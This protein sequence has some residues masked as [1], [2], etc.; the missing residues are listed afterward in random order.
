MGEPESPPPEPLRVSPGVWVSAALLAGGGALAAFSLPRLA[1]IAP[2][3]EAFEI[4]GLPLPAIV[5]LTIE[6]QLVG[7]FVLL[8]VLAPIAVLGSTIAR[9]PL[10]TRVVTGLAGA[11]VLLAVG[12]S[13]LGQLSFY[14]LVEG[15]REELAR[16][17][18]EPGRATEVALAVVEELRQAVARGV[19]VATLPNGETRRY[20]ILG[21]PGLPAP[22]ASLP[23]Y[24]EAR[25]LPGLVVLPWGAEGNTQSQREPMLLWPAGVAGGLSLEALQ[26]KGGPTWTLEIGGPS[27]GETQEGVPAVRFPAVTPAQH[28]GY[29]YALRLK[30]ARLDRASGPSYDNGLGSGL[31]PPLSR[32]IGAQDPFCDEL[33]EVQ[34]QVFR[35]FDPAHEGSLVPR[36]NTPIQRH[37]TLVALPG[38]TP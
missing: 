8:A 4:M 13:C 7:A 18:T 3:R 26:G 33:L 32:A 6:F 36:H 21:G 23:S 15:T 25:A 1:E 20:L 16:P 31:N 28:E 5:E 24:D 22:P 27:Y 37:V 14:A 35:G 11:L 30:R 9:N 19:G 12:F 34:V 29:A 10:L 2:I 17:R 38:G